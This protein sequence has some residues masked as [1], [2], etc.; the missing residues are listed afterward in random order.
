LNSNLLSSQK[1]ERQLLLLAAGILFLFAAILSLSPAGQERSWHVNYRWSHWLG[2]IIWAFIVFFEHWQLRRKIPDTDPYIYPLASLLAGIGIL[3]IWRIAPIFGLRQSLWFIVSGIVLFLGVRYSEKLPVLRRYK[4][5]LLVSGIFLTSLTL[6]FGTNPLG[7]G[8]RLWLGCCGVYLQPSEP[9]KLLLVIYL[10]AYLADNLPLRQRFFPLILP[11]LL[12]TGLALLILVVQKD[13]GT[14]SIF[15][16]L[17]TVILYL[18]TGR[19][20]VLLAS[21]LIMALAG[22]V[23][24]FA[25]DTIRIRLVAWLN[26]WSAPGGA[27]YQTIQSLMAIANGGI[28]GRGLGMG[29]PSLVPVA[30]SDFIYSAL[31]EETGLVGT[32]ILLCTM[33]IMIAR[34]LRI[35]LRAQ[36]TFRRLLA[37]GLTAYL[38]AQSMVIIGGNLRLFPLTGVTLPFISYGGSSLVTSM[39]AILLI[40][41][42]GSEPE[43]DP[44]PLVNPAPFLNLALFFNLIFVGLAMTNAWW[45]IWRSNDLLSRTDN[46]RRSIS[47]TYVAR[48]NLVDRSLLPINETQGESGSFIRQYLYPALGAVTGYTNPIYGQNGLELSVDPYLR[49][50]KGHSELSLWWNQLLYGTPPPGSTVRLSISLQIQTIADNLLGDH[51]GSA[52]LLNAKTGEV[53]AMASHPTFDPNQLSETGGELINNQDSPLV[54]RAAQGLYPLGELLTLF[55]RAKASE[56]NGSPSNQE[57]IDLYNS[58]GFYS[59]PAMQ[60][61]VAPASDYGKI[62]NL[63]LSPLQVALAATTLANNGIR[64]PGQIAM[65]VN[66]NSAEWII[67]SPLSDPVKVF[68]S[69]FVDQTIETV[70][71]PNQPYWGRA[72]NVD[73]PDSNISWFVGG[74]PSSWKGTPLIAV[75]TLEDGDSTA[76]YRMGLG[77]LK[78]AIEP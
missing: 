13:L 25:V 56:V 31:A 60:L 23:G 72:Y 29:Y 48:G 5:I 26:P 6:I 66:N 19:K 63:K 2:F 28:S 53:L 46:P 55:T 58:L 75:V 24:Y 39:I 21:I 17:Y 32:I 43:E 67:L 40:L 65:A 37:G 78:S 3:S 20:R 9:L 45:S 22:V 18:A 35:S 10:S 4:Y 61:P 70:L 77:L 42:I 33:A 57:L 50:L 12:I 68:N 14:A 1:I 51:K 16:F 11:T 59:E 7:G 44:A 74:T 73:T 64:S 15:I 62:E 54:N 38:G 47:D 71:I 69:S 41:I 52:I 49:G 27:G 76:A 36:D 30:I 8:P 34:G